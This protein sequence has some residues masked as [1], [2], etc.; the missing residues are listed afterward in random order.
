V[1]QE[2]AGWEAPLRARLEADPRASV[3]EIGLDKWIEGHDLERQQQV[4]RRQLEIACEFARPVTIH[5]LHAWGPLLETLQAF[6]ELPPGVLLHSP[7]ASA[8]V[9]R[10][11]AEMGCYFS[12]SGYFGDMR[13][14]KYRE[15]LA[16]FPLDR[17]LIETDAPDMLG[18]DACCAE[19]IS[20]EAGQPLNSPLNL[21]QIYAMVAE[22]RG[23]RLKA[24]ALQV[25]E[26][27]SRWIGMY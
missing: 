24:L 10:Q 23:L 25:E 8:E 9:V 14:K 11:L 13:K 6:G 27:F 5:C 22:A 4:F 2:P 20:D 19:Q 21:P 26:N 16:A 15:A 7:G 3:G 12:V 17:L 18:P 1:G